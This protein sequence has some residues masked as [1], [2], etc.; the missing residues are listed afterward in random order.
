ML[1]L[2]GSFDSIDIVEK[3]AVTLQSDGSRRS[4]TTSELPSYFGTHRLLSHSGNGA[5]QAKQISCKKEVTV[6]GAYSTHLL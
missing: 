2:P 3:T 6:D 5:Q 4:N 1:L